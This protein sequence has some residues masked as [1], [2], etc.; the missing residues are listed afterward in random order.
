MELQR[1]KLSL[2]KFFLTKGDK[3]MKVVT[4]AIII[5][6]DRVFIARRKDGNI[7]GKWE[8]PGGKL[9]ENETYEECLKGRFTRS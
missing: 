9:E 4:A 8:F 1:Q 2:G 6:N 5:D 3:I 7:K